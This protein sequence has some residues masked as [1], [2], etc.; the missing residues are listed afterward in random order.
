MGIYR[1]QKELLPSESPRRAGYESGIIHVLV[2]IL[3]KSVANVVGTYFQLR[4]SGENWPFSMGIGLSQI[5]LLPSEST[6]R[7]SYE[8]GI[9][10][11]LVP[12]LGRSVAHG[13]KDIFLTQS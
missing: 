3:G 7:V 13:L 2:P 12:I 9:I 11:I 6:H 4:A 10:C 8:G 5:Q 1:S